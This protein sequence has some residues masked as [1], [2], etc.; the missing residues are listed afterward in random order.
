MS[1]I[2]EQ[3]GDALS[4]MTQG[5]RSGLLRRAWK[6]IPAGDRR[7]FSTVAKVAKEWAATNQTAVELSS[8]KGSLS[9]QVCGIPI[10]TAGI[11]ATP[12]G[13]TPTK[14]KNR[15]GKETSQVILYGHIDTRVN[16]EVAGFADRCAHLIYSAACI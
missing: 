12:G 11:G 3:R 5:Q 2:S 14:R 15:K 7:Y 13:K 9:P 1:H 8:P 4:L 10:P 6:D 16:G